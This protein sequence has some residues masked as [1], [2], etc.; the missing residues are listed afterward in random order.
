MLNQYKKYVEN[1][2]YTEVVESIQKKFW[3]QFDFFKRSL[4]QD[5]GLFYK[6]PLDELERSIDNTKKGIEQDKETL[7]KM[8]ENPEVYY[9]PLKI[10]ETRL[11]Q[12]EKMNKK[13]T[14]EKAES[15]N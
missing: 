9:D 5:I 8:K 1:S 15:W 13:Q 10:F 2:T 11:V 14:V 4:P 7:A 12:Y 6:E 3:Q